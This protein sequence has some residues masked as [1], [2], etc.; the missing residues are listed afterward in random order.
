MSVTIS[1]SLAV[2]GGWKCVKLGKLLDVLG[3]C[4]NSGNEV[5]NRTSV[6]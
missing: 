4:L 6:T 2:A 3:N 5:N 1:Y